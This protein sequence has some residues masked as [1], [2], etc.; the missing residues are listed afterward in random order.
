MSRRPWSAASSGIVYPQGTGAPSLLG[1]VARIY[2]GWPSTAALDADLAAGHLNIS[3]SGDAAGQRTTTRWLEDPL[4]LTA[5]MP[6][7]TAISNHQTFLP[8]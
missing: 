1:R 8:Q 4:T 7:L 6:T 5:N 3:V 2:R